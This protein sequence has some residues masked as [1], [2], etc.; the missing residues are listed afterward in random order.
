MLSHQAC[1]LKTMMTLPRTL[2][3]Q[4]ASACCDLVA[5]NGVA[6]RVLLLNAHFKSTRST[7]CGTMCGGP[8]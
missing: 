4:T 2:V 8:P 5:V 1:L 7:K 3:I 6:S